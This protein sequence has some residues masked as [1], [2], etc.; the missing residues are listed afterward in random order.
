MG[1]V[2]EKC[3]QVVEVPRADQ[4]WRCPTCNHANAERAWQKVGAGITGAA[5]VVV[6]VLLVAT[7]VAVLAAY[8]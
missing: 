5:L 2:C 8:A 7:L 1:A 6:G 3:G 4:P